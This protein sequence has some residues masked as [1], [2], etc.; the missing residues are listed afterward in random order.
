MSTRVGLKVTPAMKA[1]F[2]RCMAILKPESV[3]PFKRDVRD[4]LAGYGQAYAG[5]WLAGWREILEGES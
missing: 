5:Q 2:D 1:D 3:E 4:V